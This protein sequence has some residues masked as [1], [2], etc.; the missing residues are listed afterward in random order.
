MP[1]G[2]VLLRCALIAACACG[3]SRELVAQLRVRD[4]AGSAAWREWWHPDRAPA[5]WRAAHPA[6]TSA[7]H[8]RVM[9]PGVE[10]AELALSSRGEAWRIRAVLVRIDP[11]KVRLALDADVGDDG[12]LRPWTIGATPDARRAVLAVN[13]GQFTDAGPWGWLVHDGREVQAPGTGSLA[14]AV[15]VDSAGRV[16]VLDPDAMHARRRDGAGEGSAGGDAARGR[17]G[18]AHRVAEAVQSYPMLLTS[19]GITP[20][21]LRVGS[22][23]TGDAAVNLAHR[24]AR[25][26]IGEQRDGRIVIALTRF[27]ALGSLLGAIPFGLTVPEMSALMGAVGCER[28]LMLDGGISAQL[29][30]ADQGGP[31]REWSGLRRVPIG[32]VATPR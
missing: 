7:M 19:G 3:T 29:A 5:E 1:T 14:G 31:R 20:R 2:W 13:A 16:Q 8:W 27:D 15:V 21:A 18:S 25:L 28:A 24:D 11:A 12:R 10:M 6:V 23:R 9:S 26:A 30:V 17:T 4:V 22:A 32:L